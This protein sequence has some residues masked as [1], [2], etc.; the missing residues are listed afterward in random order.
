VSN[1]LTFDQGTDE[2]VQVANLVDA[3]EQPLVVD[4]WTVHATAR[5]D[6][7]GGA[8]LAEWRTNPTG[9]DGTATASGRTVTLKITPAMSAAWTATRIVCQ[10]KITEPGEG[11][12][13][14]RP[15]NLLLLM[16][17]DAVSA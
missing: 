13:V 11:G 10:I 12:R 7:T 3:A 4:G 5:A 8:I 9:S 15:G 14:A 17:P 16:T 6:Y 2:I 1:V